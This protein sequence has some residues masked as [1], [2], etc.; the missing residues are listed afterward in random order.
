V[1][2][3]FENY[4]VSVVV[5]DKQSAEKTTKRK[6]DGI[7]ETVSVTGMTPDTRPQASKSNIHVDESI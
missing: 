7:K 2:K 6:C 4:R 5:T 3:T 1:K